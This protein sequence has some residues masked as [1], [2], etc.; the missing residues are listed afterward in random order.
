MRDP[1][2]HAP[3]C[4]GMIAAKTDAELHRIWKSQAGAR[5]GA[6]PFRSV[7]KEHHITGIIRQESCIVMLRTGKL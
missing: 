6:S 7:S 1:A 2:C 4:I 3:D 5:P